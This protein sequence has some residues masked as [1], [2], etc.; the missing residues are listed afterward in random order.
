MSD[1][2]RTPSPG[3]PGLE[4]PIATV[5]PCPSEPC[6]IGEGV[7]VTPAPMPDV[8]ADTGPLDVVAAAL[9]ALVL[10]YAGLALLGRPRRGRR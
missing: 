4:S 6:E 2:D 9:G 3:I 5:E 1:P 8:L 7:T 10:L